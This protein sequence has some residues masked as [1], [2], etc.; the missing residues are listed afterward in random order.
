VNVADEMRQLYEDEAQQ[1]D[2]KFDGNVPPETISRYK[3]EIEKDLGLGANRKALDVGTGTGFI[4]GILL[5]SGYDV[6]GI[7]FSPKMLA[8]ATTKYPKA[9]FKVH[10]IESDEPAFDGRFDL[11]T[12]RQVVGHFLD[13]IAVFR[14][15]H[16]WLL[17]NGQVVIID[18]LWT[19]DDWRKPWDKFVDYLPLACTES[20]ATVSDLLKQ[21]QFSIKSER[22]LDQ[23]NEDEKQRPA[24][25]TQKPKVRYI[26]VGQKV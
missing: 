15:W 7:D 25:E 6:L 22:F 18:A 4:T 3:A 20:W 16:N 10:D 14:R 26:V 21:A 23:V 9:K 5:A 13:P 2:S 19:R 1:Y 12:S 8:V 11:I 24:A 17:P